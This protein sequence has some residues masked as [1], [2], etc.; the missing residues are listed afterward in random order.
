M[1]SL[2]ESRLH[3]DATLAGIRPRELDR[4]GRRDLASILK[5]NGVGAT[6]MDLFLPPQH[7]A[8][9]A[10]VDRAVAATTSAIELISELGL[11]GAIE[12]KVLCLALP[13]KPIAS[14]V[15]AIGAAG[16]ERGVTVVDFS[17]P[18]AADTPMSIAPGVDCAQAIAAGQD[19]AVAVASNSPRAIRLCDWSGSR[20]VAVGKGGV[21][22]RA[23]V[24]SASIAAAGAPVVID[25]RGVDGGWEIATRA[26]VELWHGAQAGA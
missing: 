11:L 19:P 26:A 17:L 1:T 18:A 9:A 20:R 21:D 23:L 22:V 13:P 5:R 3:L 14:A 7:L 8:E 24:A 2:G 15:E 6:G 4:S 10:H 12:S 25:L 16:L